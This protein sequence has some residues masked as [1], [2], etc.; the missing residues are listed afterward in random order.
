MATLKMLC[1]AA[2]LVCLGSA[3][4]IARPA[5]LSVRHYT[6]ANGLA[7]N[8]VSRIYRDS[9]D[10]LWICTD[11][12]LSR[13]DGLH[14]VNFTPSDGLPDVHVNDILEDRRDHYWIG[15]DGGVVS[16]N[17]A[18]TGDRFVTYVPPGPQRARLVNTVLVEKDGSVLLGTS[19]GLYRMRFSGLT[20]SF[21]TIDFHPPSYVL[22]GSMVNTLLI[23][24]DGA[25]WVGASSGL[26]RRDPTGAW[27]WLKQREGLPHD[28][29]DRVVLDHS[30]RVWA[31]TR[32]GLA[33]L[34]SQVKEG[35][36]SVDQVVTAANGL[37]H[38]DV[39][40]FLDINENERWIATLAGLVEW[41]PGAK[42]EFRTY[43]QQDGLSDQ[44]VSA[45]VIDSAGSMWAGTHNGGVNWF[46]RSP[47]ETFSVPA[48]VAFT[49]ADR[50]LAAP[51]GA[52]C[53][54]STLDTDRRVRCFDETGAHVIVPRLP[55]EVRRATAYP[56]R[57]TFIDRGGR[58]WF[59]TKFGLFRLK[60]SPLL[61]GSETPTDLRL[62]PDRESRRVFEDSRGT[63]WIT[64][65]KVHPG[66]SASEYGLFRWNASTSQLIDF[67]SQ[68]PDQARE[69]EVTSMAEDAQGE[70]WIGLGSP[71]GLFRLRG[72]RFQEIQG[73]PVGTVKALLR[74]QQ[75]RLWIASA[76][77]G[78]AVI[79]E[80]SSANITIRRFR[81]EN[82]L[83]SEQIWCLAE[84]HSGRIYLGTAKGVDRLDP[85]SGQI[86][87]LA[88]ADGLATGDIRS[89]AVDL[90]GDLWFLSPRE[91]LHFN[92]QIELEPERLK[93]RITGVRIA[94]VHTPLSINGETDLTLEA[95][96][97]YR[98]S[99]QVEF[100]AVDFVA[101][102]Q[103]RYQFSLEGGPPGWSAPS[104]VNQ[105]DFANL[106]AGHY[107]L[108][109]RAVMAAGPVDSTPAILSFSILQ[110]LWKRWWFVALAVTSALLILFLAHRIYINRRLGLERI[111]SQIAMD[112]H[113]DIGAS[114][115]RIAM[116]SEAVKVNVH[117][118]EQNT[119]EALGDIADICRSLV[120][121]MSDIVWS[122]DPQRDHIRDIVARLR[123][124][125][126]S[127]L[128]PKGVCWTCEEDSAIGATELSL[129]LRRQVYLI[130]KEA[131]N[132]VARHSGA[133]QATL[134]FEMSN[135]HLRIQVIDDGC[136]MIKRS[137]TGLGLQSMRLRTV[138]LGGKFEVND[139]DSAGVRIVLS[140]PLNGRRGA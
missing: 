48:G 104:P 128:E 15:T 139:N 32:H 57:A 85:K 25:L 114:L 56:E 50:V 16:F 125:G 130:C 60:P 42:P 22:G 65:L 55:A 36:R 91:L 135:S 33:R 71:G 117:G 138:R 74:D 136:G 6:V 23:T 58:W 123:A 111:R 77:S 68:L 61:N 134:K 93:T 3:L 106:A 70:I 21:E 124:F 9:H 67:S 112:L 72:D 137:D 140:V 54:S 40:A 45:L 109:V 46:K 95:V 12:G 53:V 89:S 75:G 43:R 38:S 17:P 94:G 4:S 132:N 30:G 13:F 69:R 51:S 97:W 39:R 90:H 34:T 27:T 118:N 73:A 37:P 8:H 80:P 122:I 18:A 115:S 105:V 10:F 66:L 26:Y 52:V 29:V 92:P 108:L 78:L 110:P 76:Q 20:P 107:R 62:L 28:F 44:E 96:P 1:R 87:H 35:Q 113:D 133:S 88:S 31:C 7:N 120:D 101:P 86:T 82:G 121:G 83:P 47:M 119:R 41:R 11:E 102:E 129:D 24:P 19:A 63:L 59:A 126:S 79:D 131:I 84:D 100:N 127:V 98:N 99:M 5:T 14:F 103:V 2:A 64:T 49:Y 116:M 81:R